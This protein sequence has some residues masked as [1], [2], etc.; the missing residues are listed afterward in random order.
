MKGRKNLYLGCS[1][2][3]LIEVLVALAI[4]AVCATV[5]AGQS[6]TSLRHQQHL[7]DKQ[8][9]LWVVKNRLAEIQL[10]SRPEAEGKSETDYD[11]AGR[12]WHVRT[13][14]S[15]IPETAYQTLVV[16]VSVGN[17]DALSSL[18]IL[19]WAG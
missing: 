3:T 13:I 5:L 6:S 9:A 12:R 2:F 14:V 7:M 17:D 1:G 15:M 10:K 4:F 19:Q 11:F 8:M 18:T 16:E